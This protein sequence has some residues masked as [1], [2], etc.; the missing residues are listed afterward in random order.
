MVFLG[1]W[2]ET[3]TL[4]YNIIMEKSVVVDIIQ[5]SSVYLDLDVTGHYNRPDVFK[6]DIN[7][8]RR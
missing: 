7:K 3:S 8:D 2:L 5:D 6:L 1:N 4:I